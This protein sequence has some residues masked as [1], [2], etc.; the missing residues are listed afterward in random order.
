MDLTHEAD[1]RKGGRHRR[2]SGMGERGDGYA[3]SIFQ[4]NDGLEAG[5]QSG[6]CG[7]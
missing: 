4:L 1:G 5:G 6:E 7:Y 2:R 3:D